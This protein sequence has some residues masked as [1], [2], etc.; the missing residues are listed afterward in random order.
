M[1]KVNL[2]VF[3]VDI[4]ALLRVTTHDEYILINQSK[5]QNHKRHLV[6]DYYCAAS[7]SVR[8]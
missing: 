2:Q 1:L 7:Q 8:T 5:Q 4:K 6:N 3:S